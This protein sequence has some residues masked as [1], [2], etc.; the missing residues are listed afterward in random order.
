MFNLL[1]VL[2]RVRFDAGSPIGVIIVSAVIIGLVYGALSF[3]VEKIILPIMKVPDEKREDHILSKII[4]W[5]TLF[6]AVVAILFGILP[7]FGISIF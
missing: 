3:V 7:S 2:A 4:L 1:T 6:L 5:F